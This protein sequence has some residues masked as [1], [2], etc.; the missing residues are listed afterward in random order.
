M[1]ILLTGACGFVGSTVARALIEDVSGIA[2]VGFDNLVRAGSERNRGALLSLG[3]DLRH[4]DVRV[5]SDFDQLPA[6]DWV[7]DAAANPSVLAGVDGATSSRQ[8]VEHNLYGTVNLL[9]FCKTHKAG[10]ILLSTSRV[11][12]IADLASLP[13]EAHGC[14]VRLPSHAQ[15]PAG[16][17]A[18]GISEQFSTTPPL[19]LYG[20]AKLA[21][22]VL[23]LEYADAFGFTSWIN[24][25]G[26]LA[27]AGQFGRR[28]Q[29]IFTY[30]INAWL[31]RRP[32]TYVGFDG[33][34]SQVRDCLHPRDLV[35]LLIQ[36]MTKPAGDRPRLVNLGGGL[37]QSMS[38]A[39]LSAWCEDRLGHHVVSSNPQTRKFDVPWLI[40]DA[41]LAGATWGWKPIT[42]LDAILEEIAGHAELNPE[43]LDISGQA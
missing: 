30:W 23:A 26:V 41:S 8:L 25:C 43:W 33:T 13:V 36:Q 10:F 19:S 1:K 31:R 27:G 4:G 7:I 2:I 6:V 3:V 20:S 15:L 37:P 22:E 5:R 34:G 24:R 29:G 32:L 42:A 18:H 35:P 40:M 12:S 17:S 28:D 38:L 39:Q 9:E 14:A 16:V 21:S 11:Y